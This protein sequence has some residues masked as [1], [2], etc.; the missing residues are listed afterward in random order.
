MMSSSDPDKSTTWRTVGGDLSDAEWD[1]VG[2]LFDPYWS[3]GKMGRPIKHA[4]RDLVNAIM[5][6]AATGCQ[7]RNLPACYPNWNT[8]HRYHVEWSRDGR[9]EAMCDRLRALV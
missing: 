3:Q 8:V 2:D 1:L 6:V 7:W 4:R 9:W 5:Y